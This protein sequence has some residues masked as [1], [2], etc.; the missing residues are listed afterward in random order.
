MATLTNGIT[1][2]LTAV[3]HAFID[4]NAEQIV[5]NSMPVTKLV[6]QHGDVQMHGGTIAQYPIIDSE[7]GTAAMYD[8]GTSTT[9]S[10]TTH[11]LL[12]AMEGT[13]G[14]FYGYAFYSHAQ[15]V[16]NIGGHASKEAAMNYGTVLVKAFLTDLAK[17]I[18][19]QIISGDGTSNAIKGLAKLF[20]TAETDYYGYDL[21]GSDGPS[22][23]TI[24]TGDVAD[25]LTRFPAPASQG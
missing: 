7:L 24:A 20:D 2:A 1:D 15:W 13:W 11:D 10:Q 3:T 14:F 17:L 19:T 8:G 25:L 5:T 6:K 16:K 23:V 22:S 18:E 12:G 9:I 4:D 21:T